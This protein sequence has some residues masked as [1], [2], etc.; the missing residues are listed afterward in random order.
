MKTKA[1][2]KAVIAITAFILVFSVNDNLAQNGGDDSDWSYSITGDS[3]L[4]YK[5]TKTRFGKTEH[6]IIETIWKIYL[7]IWT[8]CKLK[9]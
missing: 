7:Q 4:N 5:L 3:T 6:E 9:F 2:V 8:K 1:I